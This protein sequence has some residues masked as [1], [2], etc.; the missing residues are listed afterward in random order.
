WGE[1]RR[2]EEADW[3]APHP[4]RRHGEGARLGRLRDA[5][6]EAPRALAML[7]ERLAGLEVLGDELEV[8]VAEVALDVEARMA[9]P[10]ALEI[11][12]EAVVEDDGDH[13]GADLV[14]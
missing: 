1:A 8:E 2:A 4:Q 13:I 12:A 3:L 11:I 14:D 9:L 7:E 6:K 5:P 10:G